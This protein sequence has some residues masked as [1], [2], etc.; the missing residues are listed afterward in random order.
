MTKYLK[1]WCALSEEDHRRVRGHRLLQ[2]RAVAVVIVAL[3]RGSTG[4]GICV[5]VSS[6]TDGH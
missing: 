5:G 1:K 4:V 2:I 3:L 6:G